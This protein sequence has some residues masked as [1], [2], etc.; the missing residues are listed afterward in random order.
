MLLAYKG[1]IW[2]LWKYSK[3][4]LYYPSTFASIRPIAVVKVMTQFGLNGKLW[5]NK[6]DKNEEP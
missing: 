6:V 3:N 5:I 4:A 1:G 2:H